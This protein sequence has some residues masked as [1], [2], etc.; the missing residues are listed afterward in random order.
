MSIRSV[1]LIA[2]VVVTTALPAQAPGAVLDTIAR[3]RTIFESTCRGC[4][5]IAPP[6]Q[7]GPPMSRIAQRYVQRLG[8]RTAAA[9][10]IAEWLSGPTVE[11]SLLPREEVA[12]F[13]VMPHQPLADAGRF[14]VAAYVVTLVDSGPKRGRGA[15]R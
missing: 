13:G 12:R 15:R 3:G 2:S 7:G 5:T 4:H 11:K 9:G 8:S 6:P 1:L 10:R 14:A